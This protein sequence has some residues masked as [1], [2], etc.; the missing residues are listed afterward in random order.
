MVSDTNEFDDQLDGGKLR[1]LYEKALEDKKTLTDKVTVFESKERLRSVES[2]LSEKGLNPKL[3]R[4]V[5]AEE[6]SDPARLDTWLKDNADLFAPATKNDDDSA[7][8]NDG[9]ASSIPTGTAE[10]FTK[11]AKV[12]ENGSHSVVD[13]SALQAQMANVKTEAEFNA[14]VS[15]YKIG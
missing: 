2:A 12:S 4:F 14:L 3:A 9:G 11:I 6:G 8:T 13:L 5:P 7:D 15:Q 10:A 1:K